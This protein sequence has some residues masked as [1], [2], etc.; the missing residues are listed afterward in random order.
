MKSTRTLVI[1][2]LSTIIGMTAAAQ[3]PLTYTDIVKADSLP[4]TELYTRA[5]LWFATN[6]NNSKAVIQADDKEAGQ[7]IGKATMRYEPTFFIASGVVKGP[8]DYTISILLKDGRFK[9]EVTDFYHTA[10]IKES[11]FNMGLM[12]EGGQSEAGGCAEYSA[13]ID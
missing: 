1:I 8:V 10:D 6:Y 4:A 11:A 13:G 5:K 9:Y 3:T 2:V 12:G 7:I